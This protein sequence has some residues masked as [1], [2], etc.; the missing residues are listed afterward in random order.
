VVTNQVGTL[1]IPFGGS[2]TGKPAPGLTET[3]LVHTSKNA[4]PVDLIIATLTGEPATR[5]YQP[6]GKEEPLAI[7]LTGKFKTAFPNG[8]PQPYGQKKEE[9]KKESAPPPKQLMASTA[10]NSV[11]LVGDADML[12]DGAAVDVQDVFGQRLVVPRNGN[13][14]FAQGFVE[15]FAGDQALMSLRSRASFVRP[16]TVIQQMESQA[17][18][19]YLGKI[20]SLEDNLNQTQEKLQA[21]QKGRGASAQ[22]STILTPE[23]QTEIEN[24]RKHAAETRVALKEL[25]KNLRVETDRLEIWTKVVNIALVPLLVAILGLALGYA[26]RRHVVEAAG[27]KK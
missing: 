23:Q 26:R 13:L 6:T 4:M 3:V 12:S 2:F 21:L 20:K 16:L 15:Q 17:Q 9:A 27:A 10:E 22:Q 14:A 7:R 24:F 11:V 18:E 5:G 25:R 19:A 1:L 8:K